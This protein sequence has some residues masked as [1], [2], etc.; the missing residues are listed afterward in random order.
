MYEYIAPPL[1]PGIIWGYGGYLTYPNVKYP[2]VGQSDCVKS[3]STAPCNYQ[4]DGGDLTW[5]AL[6]LSNAPW[7]GNCFMSLPPIKLHLCPRGEWWR[8]IYTQRS[9]T[10]IQQCPAKITHVNHTINYIIIVEIAEI[11]RNN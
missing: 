11:I 10:A 7:W 4:S 8:N 1:S 5:L 9:I 3:T 2:T 6:S